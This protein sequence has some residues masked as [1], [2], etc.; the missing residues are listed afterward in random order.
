[1]AKRKQ[2]AAPEPTAKR[3]KGT[4]DASVARLRKETFGAKRWEDALSLLAALVTA[5]TKA[6]KA[7]LK[8]AQTEAD[9]TALIGAAGYPLP[10]L[11]KSHL[12]CHEWW[13]EYV[14][15]HFIR[16]KRPV[17]LLIIAEA[18]PYSAT[19]ISYLYRPA[20]A[21]Y[22]GH[23]LPQILKAVA[24]AEGVEPPEYKAKDAAKKEDV[25]RWLGEH[26]VLLMDPL[27]FALPYSGKVAGEDKR[28]N[29]RSKQDGRPYASLCAMGWRLCLERIESAGLKLAPGLAVAFS[30]PLSG[31]ALLGAHGGRVPLPDGKSIATGF[32]EAEAAKPKAAARKPKASAKAKSGSGGATAPEH[33]RC[34]FFALTSCEWLPAR[35]TK[36]TRTAGASFLIWQVGLLR[37]PG[38]PA[39]R[40]LARRDPR[41]PPTPEG[42][43]VGGNPYR[44]TVK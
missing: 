6:D 23:L 44:A 13:L 19:D 14:T 21:S 18:P 16:A 30:L 12:T 37:Q 29:L 39:R 26:G 43:Q 15:R 35:S 20:D 38:R 41:H 22:K 9:W 34:V 17:R 32:A 27:P 31:R 4:T 3:S 25:M 7:A 1:M 5:S 33:A 36:L 2:A 11:A 24:T 10:H 8:A 28:P 40:Q 42:H